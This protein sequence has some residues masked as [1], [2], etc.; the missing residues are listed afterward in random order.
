M[1]ERSKVL[2]FLIENPYLSQRELSKKIGIS[3]GK[4]NNILKRCI[5]LELINKDGVSRNLK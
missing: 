1:E 2:S 3:L 4:I 5:E